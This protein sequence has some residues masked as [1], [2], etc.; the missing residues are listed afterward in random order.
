MTRLLANSSKFL[1]KWAKSK[2]NII[3]GKYRSKTKAIKSKTFSTIIIIPIN[4]L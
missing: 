1:N 2:Q 3:S 4:A